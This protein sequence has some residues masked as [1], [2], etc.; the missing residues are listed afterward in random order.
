MSYWKQKDVFPIIFNSLLRLSED[1]NNW[2][3]HNSIVNDIIGHCN[4]NDYISWY[5]QD[6]TILR[7]IVSNMVAWFSEKYTLFEEG[8]LSPNEGTYDLIKKVYE[9]FERRKEIENNTYSY[10][11][12][13]NARPIPLSKRDRNK[14]RFRAFVEYLKRIKCPPEEYRNLISKWGKKRHGV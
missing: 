2:I 13:S 7:E 5:P 8:E 4:I 12:L 10:R 6:V 3:S 1:N 11:R 9:T 14:E